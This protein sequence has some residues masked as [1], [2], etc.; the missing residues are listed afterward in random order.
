MDPFAKGGC[1]VKTFDSAEKAC[2]SSVATHIKARCGPR[3]AGADRH[4]CRAS[5]SSTALE[6]RLRISSISATERSRR[7]ER[8]TKCSSWGARRPSDPRRAKRTTARTRAWTSLA[9]S[10]KRR[11]LWRRIAREASAGDGASPWAV[12]R[13]RT[14]S[15]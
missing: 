10:V 3:A 12:E 14:S 6:K 7:L 4:L 8:G 2:G 11:V 5:R 1:D 15:T 9:V 13:V